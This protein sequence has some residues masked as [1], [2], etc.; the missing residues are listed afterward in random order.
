MSDVRGIKGYCA[1]PTAPT[2][3]TSTTSPLPLN[4]PPHAADR[5]LCSDIQQQ[6]PPALKIELINTFSKYK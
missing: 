5:H 3:S 4:S 6:R 2:T 1:T